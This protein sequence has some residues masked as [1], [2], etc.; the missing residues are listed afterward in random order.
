MAPGS[1]V[2]LEALGERIGYRFR[3]PE[4][5]R[6]AL[7]HPSVGHGSGAGR[8][9]RRNYDRLEFLGDR[10]LGVVIAEL[11][12][13]RDPRA[14]A[15]RLARRYNALV[16]GETLA[17]IADRLGLGDFLMMSPGERQ[18]GGAAK[19]AI[20]ANTLEALIAA[21]HL[22]GGFE[23]AKGFIVAH[24]S[25]LAEQT[26]AAAK[27]AKTALQEWAHAQGLPAPDY[28]IVS[29]AGPDHAPRF[30]I[31]AAIPDRGA[32]QAEAGSKRRA[33]QAAAA[34]LLARFK[35]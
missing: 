26:D 21:I 28:R 35:P 24:W 27:D 15:G 29:Q 8:G 16:R 19:P 9:R 17:G 33:E 23:A 25:E 2:D 14:D 13:N 18:S 5:I 22:D 4:L 7:T 10:V 1:T 3:R 31:E 20:L 34:D 12:H 32:A 6:E 11:L 30:V